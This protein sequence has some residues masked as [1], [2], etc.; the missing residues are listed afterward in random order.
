M[1]RPTIVL[2]STS[3]YRRELLGRLKIAF[4]VASPQVDETPLD[5]E[6][7]RATALRLAIAKAQEVQSRYL[8]AV[9]IGSDQVAEID[10]A[11]LG[12]PM[13]HPAALAQLER[14]QG[15]PVT[16]HT[17]LAVAGPGREA[18]Q[19]D[20]VPT[21]VLMRTLPRTALERY[22]RLDEPY[23]CAGAAKIESLGIALVE[24]VESTDPTALIGLPLIRLTAM[25]SHAG[26]G[27]LD[28]G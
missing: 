24:S 17:A 20:A 7:P 1:D 3:R 11:A 23:D 28:P 26:I 21:T 19:V 10:G 2:A 15:K 5:R 18:L 9:V 6:A 25:L 22:L 4:E 27:I 8:G 16:F 14:M 13:S 12:K